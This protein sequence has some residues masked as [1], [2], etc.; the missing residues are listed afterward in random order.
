MGVGHW[1][2]GHVG[3]GYTNNSFKVG[4]WQDGGDADVELDI[5][6]LVDVAGG[7]FSPLAV[8]SGESAFLVQE[9]EGFPVGML[10]CCG[11]EAGKCCG[12]LAGC[13]P[14][15]EMVGGGLC[16][17]GFARECGSFGFWRFDGDF[18]F[19]GS[20]LFQAGGAGT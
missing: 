13:W 9:G 18:Q 12:G 20:E 5:A 3:N 15:G 4:R 6:I 14:T 7:D 1:P 8:L 11:L 10:E 19:G 16:M 2:A 17:E